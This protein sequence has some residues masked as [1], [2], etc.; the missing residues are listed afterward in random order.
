[1]SLRYYNLILTE[2]TKDR[3]IAEVDWGLL[4]TLD[5]YESFHQV[6]RQTDWAKLDERVALSVDEGAEVTSP[7][8]DPPPP[9]P[10]QIPLCCTCKWNYKRAVCEHAGVVVSVFSGEYKVPDKLIAATPAL[11]KKTSS[12]RGTAG[13]RRKH[14]LKELAKAKTKSKTRLT[15]M[16]PP[17]PRPEPPVAAPAVEPPVAAEAGPP[18]A[19]KAGQQLAIPPDVT[20]PSDDEVLVVLLSPWQTLTEF[21]N[22]P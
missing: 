15:Y 2:R 7:R 4:S 8:K 11:R 5:V 10:E 14:L 20:Y 1:M 12:I 6:G 3:H 21:L 19:E 16:D 22:R 9:P 18:V 13:V 17:A